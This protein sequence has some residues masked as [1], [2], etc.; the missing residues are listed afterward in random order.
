MGVNWVVANIID[1]LGRF[2]LPVILIVAGMTAKEYFEKNE[3]NLNAHETPSCLNYNA[4]FQE[5][6]I[7]LG[8]LLVSLLLYLLWGGGRYDANPMSILPGFDDI[9]HSTAY[10]FYWAVL[11]LI[12]DIVAPFLAYIASSRP[13]RIVLGLYLCFWVVFVVFLTIPA[14]YLKDLFENPEN[15]L[16][17]IYI[18]SQQALG[19]IHS[20]LA[21]KLSGYYVWGFCG[22]EIFLKIVRH[23]VIAQRATYC[24]A[25]GSLLVILLIP[26]LEQPVFHLVPYDHIQ[27]DYIRPGVLLYALSALAVFD[28][29]QT[30]PYRR[31]GCIKE[32]FTKKSSYFLF[33]GLYL[34][35]S[36]LIEVVTLLPLTDWPMIGL[37]KM[38]A[39]I[40]AG[41]GI[42]WVITLIDPMHDPHKEA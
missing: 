18:T 6:L 4:F 12:Y 37:W 9:L 20:S 14:V 23:N 16:K 41:L 5:R 34:T 32:F 29:W 38:P 22:A 40:L 35:H 13:G 26:F 17:I 8:P 7:F 2:A 1:A 21:F 39:I 11:L 30:K 24:V 25:G 28:Q 15:P 42:G 33:L 31:F 27:R 19:Y 36:A 3:K 10:P